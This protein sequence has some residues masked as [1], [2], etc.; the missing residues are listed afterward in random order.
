MFET[1]KTPM[2]MPTIRMKKKETIVS[3][4]VMK[5]PS[6][7]LNEPKTYWKMGRKRSGKKM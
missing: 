1:R 4:R 6:P 3:F 5:M 7:A 2:I